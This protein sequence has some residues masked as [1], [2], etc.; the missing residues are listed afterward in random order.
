MRKWLLSLLLMLALIGCAVPRGG[1]PEV[2]IKE[3]QSQPEAFQD[4]LVRMRGYGVIV[5]TAPLCPGYIGLDQR[6]VFVDAE[7]SKITAQVPKDWPENVRH[8][9]PEK[10]RTFEG[11]IRIFKGEIGCPGATRKE[12]IPYF[13]ITR[14]V[15]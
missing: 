15:P 13:E 9:E 3:V 10:V 5:A 11:Y 1:V 6:T 4:K 2:S 7:G 8:Y 12:V 14:V